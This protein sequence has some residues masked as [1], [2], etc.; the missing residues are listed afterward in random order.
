M[1]EAQRRERV[2]R[3]VAD[4]AKEI[5]SDEALRARLGGALEDNAFFFHTSGQ[6]ALARECL[7]LAG[8]MRAGG[9]PPAFFREMVHVTLSVLLERLARQSETAPGPKGQGGPGPVIA[10]S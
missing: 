10:A 4:A 2:D 1:E 6:P 8:E 3:I 7:T 5:F 9:E